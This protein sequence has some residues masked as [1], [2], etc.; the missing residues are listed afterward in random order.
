[1]DNGYDILAGR[2]YRVVNIRAMEDFIQRR[3]DDNPFELERLQKSFVTSRPKW[4][5][6]HRGEKTDRY[7]DFKHLKLCVH[8]DFSYIFV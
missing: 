4:R 1:M 2:I 3:S 6:T 8:I 5:E 7:F